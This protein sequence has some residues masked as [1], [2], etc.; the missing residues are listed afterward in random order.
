[1]ARPRDCVSAPMLLPGEAHA[2]PSL[3]VLRRRR[4]ERLLDHVISR[5]RGRDPYSSLDSPV[6]GLLSVSE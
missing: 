4:G 3:S 6:L 5:D 1:M 2:E